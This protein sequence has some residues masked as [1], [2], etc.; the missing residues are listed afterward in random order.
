MA[1]EATLTIAFLGLG[2]MGEPMATNLLRTLPDLIVW[3]RSRPALDRLQA[4]GATVAPDA[5]SALRA[6]S[7]AFLMLANEA[8]IDDVLERE[9][10]AFA[11]NVG[12]RLIVHMGTTSPAF[13]RGLE[14]AITQA[15]G[16]YVEA[17]VSGSRVPA[18]RGALAGMVAGGDE[19]VETIRALIRPI[20]GQTFACGAAPGALTM[21][22]S[23]NLFLITM[24]TGLMEAAQFAAAHSLDLDLFRSIIEAGPMASD[25]SRVKLDKLVQGDFTAQASVADVRMNSGLVA[26][27]ARAANLVTPLLDQADALYG[28]AEQFGFGADDMIGVIRVL[29]AASRAK[30][31]TDPGETRP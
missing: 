30:G 14:A 6:A 10:D 25:V 4:L 9:S 19:D 7:I 12:G 2:R 3:N 17:P 8:A 13:S 26:A 5:R 27:A 11:A 31:A 29:Q 20:C 18:E 16:R 15:G 28:M 22:L 23:V 24:V 1:E 21:K